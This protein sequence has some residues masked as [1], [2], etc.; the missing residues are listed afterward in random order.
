MSRDY[1]RIGHR[2][3]HPKVNFSFFYLWFRMKTII[4]IQSSLDVEF[5]VAPNIF[6]VSNRFVYHRFDSYLMAPSLYS[7]RVHNFEIKITIFSPN[8][9]KDIAMA[10]QQMSQEEN[11]KIYIPLALY[12]GKFSIFNSS[13]WRF[14]VM[15]TIYS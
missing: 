15:F 6:P 14:N 12:L 3:S 5:C 10:F 2:W 1:R 8:R 9:L 4:R 11:N 7:F 13:Q